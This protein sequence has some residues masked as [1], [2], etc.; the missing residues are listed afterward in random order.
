M[1]I[2]NKLLTFSE[3]ALLIVSNSS[4][5]EFYLAQS[6]EISKIADFKIEKPTYSDRE[7]YGRIPGGGV[8]ESGTKYDKEK[9]IMQR[10]F[11][12]KFSEILKNIQKRFKNIKSIY[13]VT[14]KSVH[15][16]MKKL[17]PANWRQKVA[18]HIMGDFSKF[19]IID[20]L[21]RICER[22]KGNIIFPIAAT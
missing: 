2:S 8:Y 13:L 16:L 5:A 18:D 9:L 10:E 14:A 1:K 11:K 15:G 20:V 12:I 7:D 22:R 21:K 6:D 19:H 17:L 4:S 3:P